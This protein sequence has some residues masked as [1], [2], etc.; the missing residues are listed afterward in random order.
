MLCMGEAVL[1]CSETQIAMSARRHRNSAI[2][3]CEAVRGAILDRKLTTTDLLVLSTI[4]AYIGDWGCW[5][6]NANIA[7]RAG[8]QAR[9]VR[10]VLSKLKEMEFVE[11]LD[12]PVDNRRYIVTRW[13]SGTLREQAAESPTEDTVVPREGGGNS[14][15]ATNG[16]RQ[17]AVA[18]GGRQPAIAT[19]DTPTGYLKGKRA[20]AEDGGSP[21]DFFTEKAP[22]GTFGIEANP[23]QSPL[24]KQAADLAHRLKEAV[25]H[26]GRTWGNKTKRTAIDG[27]MKLLRADE[28][29]HATAVEV[30]EWYHDHMTDKFVPRAYT[31]QQFRDKF[32]AIQDAMDRAET[33]GTPR[34]RKANG[35]PYRALPPGKFGPGTNF[36]LEWSG[37]GEYRIRLREA[38][39]AHRTGL[40]KYDHD[41]DECYEAYCRYE[42]FGDRQLDEFRQKHGSK[43][44]V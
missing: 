20:P 18:G 43:Y 3:M 8:I 44:G 39:A 17:R 11:V 4:D 34:L 14:I 28:V 5:M 23:D 30:L 22:S 10:N 1:F 7:K 37:D 16:G 19:N 24:E 40:S 42:A 9:Q 6:S 21:A 38:M 32:P 31:A 15:A 27:M 41:N 25:C 13:N 35:K 2:W 29:P 26:N 33:K 36:P 12:G